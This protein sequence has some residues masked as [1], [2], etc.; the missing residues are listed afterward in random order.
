MTMYRSGQSGPPKAML[1]T[2]FAG[3]AISSISS[4]DGDSFTTRRPPTCA[5]QRLP[6]ASTHMPSGMPRS[7]MERPRRRR[8]ETDPTASTSWAQIPFEVESEWYSV[9]PSGEKPMPLL[10]SMPP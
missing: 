9:A 4:P 10:T 5:T 7:K 8:L 3:T 1:V 6:S 2:A